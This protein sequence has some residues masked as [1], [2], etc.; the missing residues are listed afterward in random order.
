MTAARKMTAPPRIDP[1]IDEYRNKLAREFMGLRTHYEDVCESLAPHY[2]PG[3]VRRRALAVVRPELRAFLSVVLTRAPLDAIERSTGLLHDWSATDSLL[4]GG[5]NEMKAL[6]DAALPEATWTKLKRIDAKKA[7]KED[8][9]ARW[10]SKWLKE[11]SS[12]A[13]AK[14]ENGQWARFFSGIEAPEWIVQAVSFAENFDANL[15]AQSRERKAANEARAPLTLDQVIPM[16]GGTM[17][18]PEDGIAALRGRF[19]HPEPAPPPAAPAPPVTAPKPARA[20]SRLD[21]IASMGEIEQLRGAHL[22]PPLGAENLDAFYRWC[23]NEWTSIKAHA[24]ALEWDP[25]RSAAPAA[26]LDET[27]PILDPLVQLRGRH[28]VLPLG[29]DHDA[30]LR[31]CFHEWNTIKAHAAALAWKP[32]AEPAREDPARSNT[33]PAE[34]DE[35]PADDTPPERTAS[36]ERR[37]AAMEDEVRRLHS[38]LAFLNLNLEQQIRRVQE[39][40]ERHFEVLRDLLMQIIH[41]TKANTPPA[42]DESEAVDTG[43]DASSDVAV[44]LARDIDETLGAGVEANSDATLRLAGDTGETVDADV[45][46]DASSDAH[47][48]RDMSETAEASSGNACSDVA[49]P[50]VGGPDKAMDGGSTS[51]TESGNSENAGHASETVSPCESIALVGGPPLPGA[52]CD[53]APIGTDDDDLD[54]GDTDD[55]SPNAAHLVADGQGESMDASATARAMAALEAQI[56]DL[57]RGLSA[58]QAAQASALAEQQRRSQQ[59]EELIAAFGASHA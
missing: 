8:E 23:H 59:F 46:V 41:K 1:A 11:Y 31:W 52:T 4:K 55:A 25:S 6:I 24:A 36:V 48:A 35:A 49:T 34:P 45:N 26:S 2:G 50:A 15:R 53:E 58:A 42:S 13:E 56:G 54:E 10:T 43:V 40:Q 22:Q 21:M 5:G 30:F 16:K 7:K 20:P 32:S 18:T 27:I 57:N 44:S 51:E 28:F 17:V 3:E 33:P 12:H 19:Q 14:H 38:Q 9:W 47:L 37:L 29:T 39:E